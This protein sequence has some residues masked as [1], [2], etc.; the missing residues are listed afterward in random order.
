M[1]AA[2]SITIQDKDD[3][4]AGA[5]F[6]TALVYSTSMMTELSLWSQLSQPNHKVN[7]M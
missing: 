1:A 7:L 5:F 4:T 2:I 6:A 3:W